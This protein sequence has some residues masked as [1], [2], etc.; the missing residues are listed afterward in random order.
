MN[1]RIPRVEVADVPNSR[2]GR[3]DLKKRKKRAERRA[4]KL[5]PEVPASYGKYSGWQS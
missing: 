4:A 1:Y 5:N 3:K 2:V